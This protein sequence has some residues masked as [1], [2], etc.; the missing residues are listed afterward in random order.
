MCHVEVQTFEFK[1]VPPQG[2]LLFLGV[3]ISLFLHL[4]SPPLAPILV[5]FFSPSHVQAVQAFVADVIISSHLC[6]LNYDNDRDQQLTNTTVESGQ[7]RLT[8][9]SALPALPIPLVSLAL[10]LALLTLH[11]KTS[12]PTTKI[13]PRPFIQ[14]QRI[15]YVIK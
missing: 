10:V 6:W 13:M 15:D 3:P 4:I 5:V 11:H 2:S 8:L 1:V 12:T 14:T 7:P 9:T